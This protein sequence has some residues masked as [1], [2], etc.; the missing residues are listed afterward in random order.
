MFSLFVVC[1]CS[2]NKFI[3]ASRN[4]K[5]LQTFFFRTNEQFLG[6]LAITNLWCFFSCF[7]WPFFLSTFCSHFF[8]ILFGNFFCGFSWYTQIHYH[9]EYGKKIPKISRRMNLRLVKKNAFKQ[10][11]TTFRMEK[12]GFRFVFIL[13]N[14]KMWQYYTFQNFFFF[15]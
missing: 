15:P 3:Q 11:V 5:N 13:S 14:L 9:F 12:N 8:I 6:P 2:L 1:W 7:V 10:R 4:K